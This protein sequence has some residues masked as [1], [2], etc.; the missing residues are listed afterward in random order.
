MTFG[1]LAAHS[2]IAFANEDRL[3]G[4][5]KLALMEL[6]QQQV[7]NALSSPKSQSP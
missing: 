5:D 3:L 1:H 2:A 7:V 4:G 6:V